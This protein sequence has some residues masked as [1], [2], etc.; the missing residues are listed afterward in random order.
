M[1]QANK[2]I[3]DVGSSWSRR[4]KCVDPSECRATVVALERSCRIHTCLPQVIDGLRVNHRTGSVDSP[5][6]TI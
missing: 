3:V 2:D 6:L 5:I 4:D 1:A